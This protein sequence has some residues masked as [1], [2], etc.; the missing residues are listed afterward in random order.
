MGNNWNKT[1]FQNIITLNYGKSLPKTK[2]IQG[3]YNVYGSG[4]IVGTHNELLV[5]GPVI[6]V[7]RKG[8]VGSLFYETKG[9]FPIDTTY[10]IKQSS[11]YNLK[12][13][14]YLLRCSNIDKMNSHSAVPGLNRNDLYSK[15]VIIPTI[16]TQDK[17]VKILSSL[18]NKI[19]LNNEMNK[20]LEEMAQ[21]LFKSWFVDFEPFKDGEFEESELGLI[22]KGWK[23]CS[24]KNICN[25]NMGQSPSSETYN[26]DKEGMSFYQGVKDFTERFPLVSTYCSAPK[27]VAMAGD[28]LLSVRAPVGRIN[29]SLEKCCIGRGCASLSSEKYGNGF[30][31]YLL[32]NI[33]WDKYESG[34]VFT[35]IKKSDIENYKVISPNIDVINKFNQVINSLDN[36]IHNN[37]VQNRDL[38]KMRDTLLPKLISG[39]MNI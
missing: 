4:G 24:L 38:Q 34:T 28:I 10:Y 32:R 5:D 27:K 15:E 13:I 9:C 1:T 19:K 12:F 29:I 16:D 11:K 14:Y 33:K 25:I 3:K 18:D 35:S 21:A 36:R 17:I 6:V 20:T 8:T 30:L 39:Q 23:V 7:G 31:Y 26:E 2:R 22:P 37:C